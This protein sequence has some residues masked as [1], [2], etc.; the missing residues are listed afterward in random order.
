M[1]RNGEQ[2][3]YIAV[4]VDG[5]LFGMLDPEAFVKTLSEKRGG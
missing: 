3:E 1:H 5:L 4:Y 2:Y